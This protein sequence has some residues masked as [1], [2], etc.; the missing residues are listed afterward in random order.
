M[1]AYDVS[2]IILSALALAAR[3][4]GAKCFVL[5]EDEDISP[6]RARCIIASWAFLLVLGILLFLAKD[7][8]TPVRVAGG[9]LSFMSFGGVVWEVM[10]ILS[11]QT[12]QQGN[13][14][15]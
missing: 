9:T 7:Y 13:K 15:C 4:A 8:D 10:A 2:I 1:D 5:I 3:L 14:P 6:N 11:I 12:E